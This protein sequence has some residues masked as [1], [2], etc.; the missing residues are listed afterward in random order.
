MPESTKM[1][2]TL[3]GSNN[4]LL[5]QKLKQLTS[6]FVDAYGDHEFERLDGE[7]TELPDL[8]ARLHSVPFFS[9]KKCIVVYEPG[10]IA[11]FRDK[12]EQVLSSANDAIDVILVESKLDKRLAYAKYL[13]KHTEFQQFDELD[14]S[15]LSR[16]LVEAA[17]DRGASLKQSDAV[18]LIQRV[19]TDQ[20]LLFNEIEKLTSYSL[21][22]TR[23]T[24]NML[25]E[26]A[27][28]SSIFELIDAAFSGKVTRALQLYDDQ[29][30]Q[31]VEPQVILSMLA[32]Q[33]HIIALT[34][35]A[36]KTKTR[37][38]IAQDS[39]LHPYVIQKAMESSRSLSSRSI[40]HCIS[41]LLDIDKRL[42]SQAINADE[43]LRSYV[44][45]LAHAQNG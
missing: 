24:I 16:W 9:D 14:E 2:Y 30:A 18:Y 11:G 40:K 3:T 20:H 29:R 43:A 4:F 45:I 34:K 41:E 36:P 33:L 35:A 10:Q 25:S 1:I 17:K 21:H 15:A 32:R 31:K 28:Q 23:E 8:Q 42:K 12:Y 39:G 37:Q 7:E 38:Q 6:A 13:K 26:P 44:V 19:G 27:P 5:K 22:I